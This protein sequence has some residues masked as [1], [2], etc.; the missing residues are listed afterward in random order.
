MYEALGLSP[1]E[2]GGD[3]KSAYGVKE[4]PLSPY[5]LQMC[6]ALGNAVRNLTQ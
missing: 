1:I 6:K 5:V 2:K 3:D 4:T